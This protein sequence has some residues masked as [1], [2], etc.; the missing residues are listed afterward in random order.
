MS[1]LL[2]LRLYQIIAFYVLS[3]STGIRAGRPEALLAQAHT[4]R[5]RFFSSHSSHFHPSLGL[6]SMR[7]RGAGR[8]ENRLS[9]SVRP[10]VV[11]ST[12][13][14]HHI[15]FTS[16][17]W[18]GLDFLPRKFHPKKFQ[19]RRRLR[20]QWSGRSGLWECSG[21]SEI[22]WCAWEGFKVSQCALYPKI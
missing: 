15:T 12:S 19:G 10:F 17:D 9:V 6:A 1:S 22:R 20:L 13:A 5:L 8:E 18:I 7:R 14:L 11:H 2:L 21:A 3:Q 16:L 4:N